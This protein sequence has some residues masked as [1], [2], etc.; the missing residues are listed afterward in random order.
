MNVIDCLGRQV[1]RWRW[2]YRDWDCSAASCLGRNPSR[3]RTVQY[4]KVSTKLFLKMRRLIFFTDLETKPCLKNS[5]SV[6]LLDKKSM[7]QLM[8]FIIGLHSRWRLSPVY[9]PRTAESSPRRCSANSTQLTQRARRM[10]ASISRERA[11]MSRYNLFYF[12]GA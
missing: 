8:M 6:I 1:D 4:R 11:G 12:R 9:W 10:S 5:V 7:H 3:S 2:S